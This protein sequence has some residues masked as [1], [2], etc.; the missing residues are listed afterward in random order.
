MDEE[1]D[2]ILCGTTGLGL[3]T[4]GLA[5]MTRPLAALLVSTAWSLAVLNSYPGFAQAEAAQV[6]ATTQNQGLATTTPS[7][8]GQTQ[9]S[10]SDALFPA[11]PFLQDDFNGDGVVDQS[12]Y[13]AWQQSLLATQSVQ[14]PE[15]ASV[16]EPAAMVL[17]VGL[18]ALLSVMGLMRYR[19]D[20]QS[21]VALA[22]VTRDR[23]S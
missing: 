5:T 8:A 10:Q 16:P 2:G 21:A 11:D 23:R 17:V 15:A 20:Q 7:T 14:E 6:A 9:T 22:R 18:V 19:F 4:L 3:A 1:V 12:D 13:A